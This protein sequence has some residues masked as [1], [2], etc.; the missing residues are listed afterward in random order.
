MKIKNAKDAQRFILGGNSSYDTEVNN[1]AVRKLFSL[2]VEYLKGEFNAYVN[3][4]ELFIEGNVNNHLVQFKM[5]K[6]VGVTYFTKIPTKW[7]PSRVVFD[8]RYIWNPN[9][10]TVYNYIKID[11][12]YH[13][14]GGTIN[15][16]L[17]FSNVEGLFNYYNHALDDAL[18]DE[19]L[20]NHWFPLSDSFEIRNYIV[21]TKPFLGFKTGDIID[22]R[23]SDKPFIW[24][25]H[26]IYKNRYATFQEYTVNILEKPPL[27]PEDVV[28]CYKQKY[29]CSNGC[30]HSCL[31]DDV[32]KKNKRLYRMF[33]AA[34][35]KLKK[36]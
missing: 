10:N 27:P 29:G 4:N 13:Y 6:F 22:K 21:I 28:S 7:T 32:K 31:A 35:E 20:K 1:K 9:Y 14:L 34:H 3:G 18:K 11:G 19:R 33:T 2:A 36:N 24:E 5:T 15:D 30:T 25:W 17:D 16:A 26:D 12:D 23:S 8:S